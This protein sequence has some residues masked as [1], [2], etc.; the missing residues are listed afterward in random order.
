MASGYIFIHVIRYDEGD[1][2]TGCG[3]NSPEGASIKKPVQEA[4][5]MTNEPVSVVMNGP[6]VRRS[7]YLYTGSLA[8][9][10][11][12]NADRLAEPVGDCVGQSACRDGG[13]DDYEYAIAAVFVRAG[14]PRDV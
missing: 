12:V 2:G 7:A 11:V 5:G 3:K 6:N 14:G 1:L 10:A 4:Q 9:Y 8:G 13:R